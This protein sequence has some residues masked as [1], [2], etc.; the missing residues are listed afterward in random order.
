[1]T[2]PSSKR[3]S[4]A[5]SDL[6][7]DRGLRLALQDRSPLLDGTCSEHVGNLETDEITSSELAV[8][9]GIEQGEIADGFGEFE[10]DTNSP[11]VLRQQW[12]LLTNDATVVPCPL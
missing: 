10:T 2:D 4:R 8:D 9:G 11:Y 5:I 12:A 3:F 1:M 6:E 7:S